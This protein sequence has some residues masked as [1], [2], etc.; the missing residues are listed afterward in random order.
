MPREVLLNALPAAPVVAN[1]RAM[2]GTGST[3]ARNG[4]NPESQTEGVAA[5][6]D[7]GSVTLSRD[8]WWAVV[9]ALEG[10][11]SQRDDA[12][13]ALQRWAPRPWLEALD[14]KEERERAAREA[15]EPRD[16]NDEAS[17]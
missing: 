17:Q 3:H 1:S 14:E 2:S 15:A 8:G 10:D 13:D 6:H 5:E 16:T 4:S 12:F 9:A 11:A 7:E